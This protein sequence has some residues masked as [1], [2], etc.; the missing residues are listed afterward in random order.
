MKKKMTGERLET[1]IKNQDT[2]EHLH[3]YAIVSEYIEGKVVLDIACGEGYGSNL[4]SEKAKLVYAVDI[5]FETVLSAKKKYIKENLFFK[6]GQAES[7]PITDNCIDVVVSF[8]TIEHHDKHH[9]MM[10]E[11]IRVLK[12]DGILII[13]TPDKLFYNDKR[14]FK[15]EFHIKELYKEEFTSLIQKYFKNV[16]HLNQIFINGNSHILNDSLL[17]MIKVFKG[18]FSIICEEE[19][20]PMYLIAISSNVEIIT[21]EFSVFNGNMILKYEEQI[22][23]KT[24]NSIGLKT[25]IELIKIVFL[26]LKK[27]LWKMFCL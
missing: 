9:E 12:K 24:K 4:M 1:F 3:R 7:I 19:I 2:I 23:F 17:N 18:D 22:I 14:N 20:A 25:S 10:L 21:Q 6:E 15:N 27:R 13:S 16:Q 5:D 26:R 8:E 11:I